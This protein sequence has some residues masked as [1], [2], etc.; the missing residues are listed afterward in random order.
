M[1][2]VSLNLDVGKKTPKRMME[3][4]ERIADTARKRM[5]SACASNAVLQTRCERADLPDRR[6]MIDQ[7]AGTRE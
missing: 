5:R 6:R 3:I 1:V 4:A 2:L 7:D